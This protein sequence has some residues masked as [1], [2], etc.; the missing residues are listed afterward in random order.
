MIV[1][2]TWIDYCQ[3]LSD[4][5]YKNSSDGSPSYE[6]VVQVF[7]NAVNAVGADVSQVGRADRGV[8]LMFGCEL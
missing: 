3:Y 7:E 4:E 5:F 2:K 6:E 8:N 1:T